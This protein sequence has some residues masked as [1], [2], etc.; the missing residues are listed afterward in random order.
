MA[1]SVRRSG[2]LLHLTSLPG[3]HGSGDLG[4]GARHFVDW[5]VTAGQRVWQWLPTTPIGPGHSPYQSVSAF[6]GSPWLV[7]LEPLIE[8]GWLA[9]PG[10]P[11]GGFDAQRVDFERVVPW[12]HRQLREA[13]AGFRARATPAQRDA[14]ERWRAAQGPWLED[15]ALFMALETAL[16]GRPWWLWPAPLARREGAA[17]ARARAEHAREIDFWVF[18]QWCF[19]TQCRALKAYA[20]ERGVSIMG[21]VPIFVAHHSADCWSRPD[22]YR[23][24]E[25][26]QPTVVAGAPPDDLGPEGQ[27]WGNPLYRWERMADEHYAWWIARARHALVHADLFR[28]DHFRGFAAYWEIPAELPT[29]QGGRWVAGPGRALFDAM[30]RELGPLPIVAEDLGHITPD[31]HALREACGFAGMKVLQFAFGGDAGHE[32]LPHN[33]KPHAV[34]YTGTH[35]NDTLRGWWD[36]ASERERR[37]AGAYLACGAHDVH[38]AAIRAACNSVAELAMFPLQ[39]AMGLGRDARMNTPGTMGGSNWT[40]RFDWPMVGSEPAR[41][42][43]LMAAASGRAPFALLGTR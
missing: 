27:H 34:V 41:V 42:L 16:G 5:L 24:D 26:F 17:L 6:A 31:V 25:H 7:A 35:D 33:F 29:A 40:W 20:N 23:L 22:L 12:R 13:E 28:I 4:P 14:L 1:T 2:I 11:E 36:H 39:D 3:P 18:V 19:D 9:A 38:W 32:Y 21:D 15:Y 37:F 8:A 43:A 30:A 10:L